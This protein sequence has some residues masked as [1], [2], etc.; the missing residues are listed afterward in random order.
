[1]T[2]HYDIDRLKEMQNIVDELFKAGKEFKPLNTRKSKRIRAKIINDW[3]E[4]S[5][6]AFGAYLD[7]TKDEVYKHKW[8]ITLSVMFLF[9]HSWITI[10]AGNLED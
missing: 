7:I 4:G 8:E 2:E 6:I 3:K 1:M 10:T 5:S 9:W